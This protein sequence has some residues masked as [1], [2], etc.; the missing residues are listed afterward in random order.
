MRAR[1]GCRATWGVLSAL[2]AVLGGGSVAVGWAKIPMN[3]DVARSAHIWVQGLPLLPPYTPAVVGDTI[4]TVNGM[5]I[6]TA[7]PSL[8]RPRP[9]QRPADQ[10]FARAFEAMISAHEAG[11]SDSAVA[12]VGRSIFLSDTALVMG[13]EIGPAYRNMQLRIRSH[14]DELISTVSIPH[15]RSR[16]ITR[17]KLV[18]EILAKK[19]MVET[20]LA[21]G[22]YM[23]FEGSTGSFSTVPQSLSSQL[24]AD[25]RD[26]ANAD[27][28]RADVWSAD[29]ARKRVLPF[30]MADLVAR[31]VSWE[32]RKRP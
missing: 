1:T 9:S 8:L 24:M 17:D 31:H 15:E 4:L 20:L 10:L 7:R 3:E 25:L 5:A 6:V 12:S 22:S 19:V 16:V 32:G 23:F 29:H 21:R 18:T 2:F 13:V 14:G 11:Q 26:A 30:F 28:V 27:S